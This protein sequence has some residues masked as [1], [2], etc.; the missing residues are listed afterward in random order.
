MDTETNGKRRGRPLGYELSNI[1]KD[2]IRHSRLG[3]CHTIETRNKISRSLI[4]YFKERDSIAVGLE[5]EYRCFPIEAGEW[6]MQKASEIDETKSVIS[7]KRLSYLNQME[8]C[9]G[10][11]IENFCHFTTPEFILLLKEQ[12]KE[13]GL[14]EEL[15]ELSA[16]LQEVA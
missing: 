14:V 16:L 2:K 4:K 13:E 11:E 9:F 6:I 15:Q 5:R 12:L 8:L 7:G 1:S 3:K 10:S